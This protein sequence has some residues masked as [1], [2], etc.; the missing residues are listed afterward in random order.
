MGAVATAWDDEAGGSGLNTSRSRVVDTKCITLIDHTATDGSEIL[1]EAEIFSL[2][3]NGFTIRWTALEDPQGRLI[4]YLALG[5]GGLTNVKAGGF[6]YPQ[7]DDYSETGVGFQPDVV[8]FMGAQGKSQ[9]STLNITD[10]R[11]GHGFGI[12]ISSRCAARV[13]L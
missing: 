7:Q 6:S 4:T 8:L 1:A 2:D 9:G 12:G 13:K 5:G 10:N 3:S 11:G